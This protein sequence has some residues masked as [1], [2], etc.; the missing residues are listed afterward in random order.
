LEPEAFELGRTFDEQCFIAR[1]IRIDDR[2]IEAHVPPC[3][4]SEALPE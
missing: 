1:L 4:I 2:K 3:L